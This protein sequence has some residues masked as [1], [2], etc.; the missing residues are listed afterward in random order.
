MYFLCCI[1]CIFI[2]AKINNFTHTHTK[3]SFLKFV[4]QI[5]SVCCIMIYARWVRNPEFLCL[6]S[7]SSCHQPH[8]SI[9]T[10]MY[11]GTLFLSHSCCVLLLNSRLKFYQLHFIFSISV[12]YAFSI[13]AVTSVCIIYLI[14]CIQ[15]AELQMLKLMQILG[16]M[17]LSTEVFYWIEKGHFLI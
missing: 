8:T 11:T 3:G 6:S 2:S 1:F 14:M 10:C 12:L 5:H 4:D 16:F 13:R 17:F 7:I 15:S 9:S